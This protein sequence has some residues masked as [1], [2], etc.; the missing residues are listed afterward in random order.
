MRRLDF[1]LNIRALDSDVIAIDRVGR[2]R[3]ED[4]PGGDVKCGAVPRACHLSSVDFPLTQGSADVRATIIDC[5]KGTIDIEDCDFVSVYLDH[6]CLAGKN[7]IGRSD[8][9]KLWHIC[10]QAEVFC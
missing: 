9:N 2:R 6:Y 10:F 1:Q 7:L 4:S 5:M 3:A 8:L